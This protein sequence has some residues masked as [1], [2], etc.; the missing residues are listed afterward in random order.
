MDENW[1][2]GRPG[3]PLCITEKGEYSQG[4]SGRAR[5]V[6]SGPGQGGGGC[7]RREERG[8]ANQERNCRRGG[9][10]KGQEWS[11]KPRVCGLSGWVIQEKRSL[12]EGK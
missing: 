9:Q 7:E 12:G 1:R 10:G 6:K 2:G 4:P 3:C 5:P 11:Q 8:R